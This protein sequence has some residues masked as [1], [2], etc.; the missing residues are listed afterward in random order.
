MQSQAHKQYIMPN[1]SDSI[2][3]YNWGSKSGENE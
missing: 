2:Y 3:S 1:S